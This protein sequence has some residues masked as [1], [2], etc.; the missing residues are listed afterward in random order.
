MGYVGAAPDKSVLAPSGSGPNASFT[1]SPHVVSI[2]LDDPLT[3]ANGGTGVNNGASTITIGGNVT[4]SG[5]YT[6]AGTLTGN[7]AVTFPTSGTLATTTQLITTPVSVANGGTGRSSLTNHGVLIGATT[8][9]ITQLSAGTAGQVLQSGGA[10]SDPVYTTATYPATA[11]GTGKVLIA[12]GT[13]WVA[14]T[15]TFPN[16]SATSGKIII[17]DG[18]NWTASTPTY[19]ATAGSSG[20]FLKSDGTNWS[21]AA[22]P[23]SFA[24]YAFKAIMTSTASSVTGDNTAY[25]IIFDTV[26]FDNGGGTNYSVSTGIYTVPVTGT[27]LIGGTV[28]VQNLAVGHINM[29]LSLNNSG[30]AQNY[31]VEC[32]PYIMNSSADSSS[33]IIGFTQIM[34]LTSAQQI[35]LILTISNS[36]K[37]INLRGGPTPYNTNFWG[38][39]I[40]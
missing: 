38:Y 24:P 36:T 28:D 27:W 26:A 30:V 13:N 8:S 23:N 37:T 17:S 29:L 9:A 3:G 20:N 4:I 6:F 25:S 22:V 14:S 32:N 11:T 33:L 31:V 16:A 12:D 15:P 10:S 35:Q 34:S 1:T 2:T 7:T 39:R 18:T 21:S 19:P 5:A 40:A